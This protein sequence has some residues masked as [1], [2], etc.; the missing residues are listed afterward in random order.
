MLKLRNFFSVLF[1]LTLLLSSASQRV[2]LAD[3]VVTTIPVGSIP[4]EVAVS[5][6]GT[7]AYVSNTGS[8]TVSVINTSSNTV[9]ANISV[10]GGGLQGIAVSPDNSRVYVVSSNSNS[11]A[12]INTTSLT[13]VGTITVGPSP[14]G[15]TFNASGT[16][17]YVTNF[18]GPSVSVINV[19]S[20]SVIATI[21][22]TEGPRGV[23]AIDT[24]IGPRVY[25][26]NA[27]SFNSEITVI[28]PVTNTVLTTIAT[29]GGPFF[30]AATPD[31]S[32][33]YA[34]IPFSNQ[35]V[36]INTS[37]NA[38]LAYIGT[39]GGS[40]YGVAVSATPTGWRVFTADFNG[41]GFGYD[42]SR[43]DVASNTLI[44]Q[45]FVKRRP[46]GVAANSAGTRVYVTNTGNNSVS[47]I[48]TTL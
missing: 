41:N 16:L 28:D 15:V 40:P 18:S 9:I 43:I 31:R 25:V 7:R 24:L 42:V 37:T 38:I 3:T 17:A 47:V 36:A 35:V 23:L 14:I 2:V 12:V 19:S 22:V 32:S 48:D 27:G 6:N 39:A 34:T 13:V 29:T 45:L 44:G 4:V 10:A 26:A 30:L 46:R 33:I 20:S 8:S 1:L 21:T 11:V 5:P